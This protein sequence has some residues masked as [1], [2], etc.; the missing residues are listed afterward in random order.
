LKERGKRYVGG[1]KGR[2]EKEEFVIKLNIK[3]KPKRLY[4]KQ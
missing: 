3:D 4:V 2:T 1:L